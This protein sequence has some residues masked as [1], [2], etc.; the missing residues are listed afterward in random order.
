MLLLRL[1]KESFFFAYNSIIVNKLR[2]F[3]SLLGITIGIFAIISVFTVIDAMESSVRNS[4]QSLGN[5]IIYVQ[6]WPWAFGGSYPWWKY[7]NRPVPNIT[8][9]NEIK[10]RASRVEA[11]AFSISTEKTVQY[12][13]NS[14]ENITIWASTHDFDKIRSFEIENGRYFSFYESQTGKNKAIIGHKLSSELFENQNP[15]GKNIKVFGRKLQIIGVFKKEGESML[16]SSMD[17]L[18]VIP[19]NFAR[20][21]INIRNDR[22]NPFIMVK[23]K[24]N[25]SPGALK[26]ELRRIMRGVRKLKPVVD[27]NFALNE[28]SLLTQ[29]FES[30]FA[31]IN[32]GGW[33]I[34]GFSILVGGFGIANIMFVSVK[35]RT[36]IIGIQKALGAKNY[37]ILLQFLFEAIILSLLGGILG[38]LLVYGGTL[39][40]GKITDMS[41]DLT[42]GNVTLGILISV[43]IGVISG[44]APALSA[45]KLNPV[46]AIGSV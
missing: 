30:I 26:D 25:V 28:A 35:E 21:V 42:A 17:E 36:N 3:L 43:I 10:N 37:F 9:Y 27:D 34:G 5:D 12:G 46:E 6:K 4:I 2:T 22:L 13:N 33:I 20:N 44:F 8:D 29:G 24:K 14:A 23:A 1:I 45:S 19:I 7:F 31:G 15:I 38:L 18:V 32:L 11:C 16:G 41:F 40:F 39:I